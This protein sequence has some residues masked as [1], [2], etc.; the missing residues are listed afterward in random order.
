MAAFRRDDW[1]SLDLL[2]Q[3]GFAPIER[4][5]VQVE[6]GHRRHAGD[7]TSR[8]VAGRGSLQLPLGV[9]VS[10]AWKSGDV[11]DRPM[12]VADSGRTVDD[13]AITVGF[14]STLLGLEA[15]YARTTAPTPA[16]SWSWPALGV[17]ARA[18][19]AEW[20]TAHVRLTPRNWFTIDGWHSTS[21]RG[22]P[23]EGQPPTHSMVTAAIRSKFLRVYSSGFFELKAA[24]TV[25]S[26]GTGTLGR[27][28]VGA[29]VILKGATFMRAQFQMQFGSF[30]AYWDRQNLLNQEREFVPG[31]RAL[32]GANTFG[33][34]WVFWN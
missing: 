16:A 12:I 28:S 3:V 14:E 22:D 2:A 1:T 10:G 30:I 34:R 5:A 31:I 11:V 15:G 33:I 6:G 26:W 19:A 32:A 8:W 13:R 17:V 20:L 7:R 24:A 4:L 18:G 25:E 29:P 9:V 23:I 27:D 21:A